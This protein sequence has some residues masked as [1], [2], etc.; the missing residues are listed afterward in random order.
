M[1]HQPSSCC[2]GW[3]DSEKAALTVSRWKQSGEVFSI[4]VPG[5]ELYPALQFRDRKPHP[6]VARVLAVL[7]KRKS[8]WQI[9]FWFTSSNGWL[10]GNAP[11]SHLDDDFVVGAAKRE[12]QEF[13]S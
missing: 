7:P 1:P 2:L 4:P 9:A 13:M 5:A 8:R 11:I 6:M 12:A 3:A 10:D